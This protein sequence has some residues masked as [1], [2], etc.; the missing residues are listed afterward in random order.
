MD[1]R[2][3][4][5]SNDREISVEN[6]HNNE[7]SDHQNLQDE[8]FQVYQSN[9]IIQRVSGDWIEVVPFRLQFEEMFIEPFSSSNLG[10]DWVNVNLCIF[11]N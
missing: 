9:D 6:V 2:G 8:D 1:D 3:L 5:D 11:K 4:D 10:E 7:T